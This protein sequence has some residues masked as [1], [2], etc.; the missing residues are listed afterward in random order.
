MART[1]SVDTV[2]VEGNR[3]IERSVIQAVLHASPESQLDEKTINQDL[4]AIFKLGKFSDV[5]AEVVTESGASVLIYRVV[6]RPLVRKIEITGNDELNDKELKDLNKVKTPQFYNPKTVFESINAMKTAYVEEGH[7]SAEIETELKTD[8]NNNATLIFT[9]DEG[10]RVLIDNIRFEGNT[11]FSDRELR[12]GIQTKERWIFSFITDRG[13]YNEDL[14]QND[15][16][17]ISDMYF[18]KG[19]VKVKVKQ[20][21]IT[22]VKD[23]DYLDIIIEIDEGAQFSV[24]SVGLQGDLI[25]EKETLMAL[26][27]L[28]QGAVFSR[29]VLRESMLKLN[30]YYADRGYAYVNV[31]PVTDIDELNK[32]I[33]IIYNIEKGVEV[34]IGRI[35][36]RG[37]TITVDKVIRREIALTEGDLFNSS[38][39]KESRRRI[40]NLGFFEEVNLNTQAG[41]QNDLMDIDI[42]VKGKPTGSFSLGVGYSTVDQFVA[43][44][45]VAQKNFLG[46]GLDLNV[47]GS[48][49]GTST[50]YRLG[51][52]DPYFLDSKVS[53]GFDL[54]KTEREWDDYTQKTTGGDLKFG[55]PI[56]QDVRSFFIY[57]YESKNLS[58]VNP[59][60]STFLKSQVGDSTLSSIFGSITWE[61]LDYRPD[62]T[63]G[64]RS[65]V[66]LEFAGVGGTEKFARMQLDHRHFFKGP[67]S[68]VLSAHGNIGYI[69][70]VAGEP[71][72]VSERFYLGGIRTIRGFK[73]RRVGPRVYRTSNV[74]DPNTGA[75]ISSSSDYEY[76]GGDKQAFFNLEYM[77][78]LAKEAGVKGL[79]FFD[80]GNA[81]DEDESFFSS[82]RYSVGAG[83]RWQSPMGPLRFEWGYNLKPLVDEKTSVFEFSIGSFF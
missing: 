37:N 58:D 15:L 22:I 32:Q 73:T 4:A 44:G 83:I 70:E 9:I 25:A 1:F 57:R 38:A 29:E 47:S 82:M 7:Y 19:Y 71:I 74:T 60:S 45:S 52:L 13:V 5:S 8:D 35:Q 54:Y 64:G 78:P 72:P 33:S 68:T 17:L 2:R 28:K 79:F 41:G 14:L 55:M 59:L 42:D 3:R 24:G 77:F 30:D 69:H 81:W 48:F 21:D 20:P 80:T 11:V 26:N 51:I 65:E 53:L 31:V 46:R 40:N 76:T 27:Q 10:K 63:T 66:S 18:N 6:E 43:Q 16:A 34:H 75:I 50:T 49:G 61:T 23:G 39:L 36:I 56:T 67:L 62:P 12:K